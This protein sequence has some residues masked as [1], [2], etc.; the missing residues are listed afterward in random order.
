MQIPGD[1]T[2]LEPVT[3]IQPFFGDRS[4]QD[5]PI[6]FAVDPSAQLVAHLSL[7]QVQMGGVAHLKVGGPRD[8]TARLQQIS[9]VELFGA[10]FT[11]VAAGLVITTFRAG[12]LN[13]AIWQEAAV[14]VGIDLLFGHVFDQTGSGQT[15]GK[16]L[17]QFMVLWAGRTP[18]MIK[19][20]A[21]ALRDLLLCGMHGSAVLGNR[22]LGLSR[23]QFGRC[24]MLIGGAK[25][26]HFVA[27]G[28]LIAGKQISRQLAANQI[29]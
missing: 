7:H 11:L 2:I 26:H 5:R 18:K 24:T 27:T 22:L 16:M 29:A 1:P 12:P 8:R 23:C 19:R 9:W 25:K 28:A 6:G 20:Q 14:S 4:G 17:G 21:K 3:I 10:V 15:T 13:I